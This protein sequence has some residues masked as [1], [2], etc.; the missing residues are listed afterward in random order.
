MLLP[1]TIDSSASLL[2]KAVL[3]ISPD[4]TSLLIPAVVVV[5]V[6]VVVATAGVFPV[7]STCTSFTILPDSTDVR[8]VFVRFAIVK[9][10]SLSEATGLLF[11][12]K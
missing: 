3:L 1:P 2:V 8:V 7:V 6:V 10:V 11:G 4:K 9:D 5:V 12:Y